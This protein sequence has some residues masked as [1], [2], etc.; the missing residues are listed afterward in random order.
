MKLEDVK[1]LIPLNGNVFVTLTD[2]T[3]EATNS[4]MVVGD[5]AYLSSCPMARVDYIPSDCIVE[6][7][8]YVLYRKLSEIAE[9]S[10]NGNKYKVLNQS[11][12]ISK[13][14]QS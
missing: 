10:L 2:E 6:K 11:N 5:M 9:F 4:T 12:L 14:I 8:D 13:C 1:E 3:I 7:G